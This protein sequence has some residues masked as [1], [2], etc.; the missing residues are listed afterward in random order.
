MLILIWLNFKGNEYNWYKIKIYSIKDGTMN[1][2]KLE[3]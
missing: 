3:P 1:R 2:E